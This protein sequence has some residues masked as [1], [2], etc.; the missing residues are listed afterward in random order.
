MEQ[1]YTVKELASIPAKEV[2]IATV[3]GTLNAPITALAVALQ[4]IADKQEA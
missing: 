1:Y 4:A 3:L 2:L